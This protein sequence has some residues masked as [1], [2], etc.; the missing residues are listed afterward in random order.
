VLIIS[1]DNWLLPAKS[2]STVNNWLVEYTGV[3]LRV[4]GISF[5]NVS[6]LMAYFIN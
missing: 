1:K 3:L 4:G 5:K 2:P 6:L